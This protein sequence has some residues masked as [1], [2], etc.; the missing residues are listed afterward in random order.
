[1]TKV[2]SG[3]IRLG[4]L[5]PSLDSF[6]EV[7]DVLPWAHITDEQLEEARKEFIGET[8]QTPPMFSAI[9]VKLL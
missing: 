7:S 8:F 3:T 4:E 2:Y 9:K 1:M 5:T 6:T